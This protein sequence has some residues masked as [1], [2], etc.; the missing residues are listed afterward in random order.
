MIGQ[1][2]V[3]LLK[4]SENLLALVASDSI[5]P[6]IANENTT[7]P[8]IV[9]NIDSVSPAYTKDGWAGD[10][11]DFSIIS[12]SNSYPELQEI[13]AAVR[14]SLELKNTDSTQRIILTGMLEGYNISENAFMNKMSFK[15]G[16][17]EY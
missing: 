7:L 10:V 6:Y 16:I 17:K 11:V 8:L 4:D 15:I 14:E 1:I 9:Y 2:I 12:V 5:F 13:I 3:S